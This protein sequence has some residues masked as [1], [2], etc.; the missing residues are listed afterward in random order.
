MKVFISQPMRGRTDEE[1]LAEREAALIKA[2][3]ELRQP[4]TPVDSFFAEAPVEAKP[5]W[6]LGKSLMLLAEA[7]VVYFVKG[8]Q[9][10][11]GCRVERLCAEQYQIPILE[12]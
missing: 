7:D 10:A 12:E 2:S 4:V 1:I 11:R 9:E 5:L 6:Y 8:W 3:R